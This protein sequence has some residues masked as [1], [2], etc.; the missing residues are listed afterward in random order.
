MNTKNLLLLLTS[1]AKSRNS[2]EI[3]FLH[4][5]ITTW[6][7]YYER[8]ASISRQIKAWDMHSMIVHAFESA[9]HTCWHRAGGLGRA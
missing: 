7:R 4:T 3:L 5:R 2:A 6:L 1:F 8:A 9:E